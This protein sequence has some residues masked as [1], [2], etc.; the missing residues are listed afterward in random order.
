MEQSASTVGEWR[1]E[2]EDLVRGM[3]GGLLIGI[4][5]LYTQEIWKVG[6]LT[7][8][9]TVLL[10]LAIVYVLNLVC[11]T[12]AGFRRG[13]TGVVHLLTDALE[14]T[15]LAAVTAGLVLTILARIHLDNRAS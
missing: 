10:V 9:L 11:V 5:L 7:Q 14:T 1:Q 15:A 6:A 4:P 12:W 2:A 13:K 8:L 3:T